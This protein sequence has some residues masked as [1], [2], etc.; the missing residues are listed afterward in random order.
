[1]DKEVLATSAVKDSISWTDRLK[2]YIP[3]KDREP[4]WDGSV[5]VYSTTSTC[6]DTSFMGRV[7]TQ[8]KGTEVENFREFE[9]F[10]VPLSSLR[11]FLA[12]SGVIFFVVELS[13][14]TEENRI[15]YDC[16]LPYEII[17][18]LDSCKE[19][20]KTKS[21][22]LRPF[23]NDNDEKV[24]IFVNFLQNREK[25]KAISGL[26]RI[27]PVEK[28]FTAAN[29]FNI[30][31]GYSSTKA[32][33]LS[34]YALDH[35]LYMYF[36]DSVGVTFPIEHITNISEVESTSEA[37]IICGGKHYHMDATRILRKDGCEYSFG[38]AFR[39]FTADQQ[40]E[41][42]FQ[43]RLS[44]NL[45]ERIRDC[46]F[47]LTLIQEGRFSLK[48]VDFELSMSVD[49]SD[50]E[51][52]MRIE[53]GLSCLRKIKSAL[54]YM[55]T[56]IPLDFD[57]LSEEDLR[58]IN[59][60]L[61]PASKGISVYIDGMTEPRQA[62]VL[63]IGNL[64][65]LIL[66]I[67][68]SDGTYIL[69]NFFSEPLYHIIHTDDD[70]Q[71]PCCC[72]VMLKKEDLIGLSNINFSIMLERIKANELHPI[73]INGVNL[74]LLKLLEAYDDTKR[75]DFLSTAIALSEWLCS[76]DRDDPIGL[77]NYLQAIKRKRPLEEDEKKRL[78]QI[79]Y[80]PNSLNV[81]KMGANILL[82]DFSSAELY[83]TAMEQEERSQYKDYPIMALWQ[84]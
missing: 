74:L 56:V 55:G 13:R 6:N 37:A 47:M 2:P 8:I 81:C 71:V 41:G 9:T 82:E 70:S 79:A 45:D 1:M 26:K 30:T 32:Y 53:T 60:L 21:I 54:E 76:L 49:N 48:A 25:Q 18:H 78:L 46:D 24:D 22:T 84:R 17:Q 10:D 31:I 40:S 50:E 12:E 52:Y 27:I 51:R 34:E 63:S 83:Y 72:Y 29:P 38:K 7:P 73:Y 36:T 77:I 39:F 67:Q 66:G 3:E 58:K 19:S 15:F 68:Q 20:Q 69:S 4:I 61:I 14:K 44:G 64:N 43:F 57:T 33:G 28:L 5:Y 75:D 42:A 23:P 59:N 62:G 65:L 80:D 35:D 16:L 11:Q